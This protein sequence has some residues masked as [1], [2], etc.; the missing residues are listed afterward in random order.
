MGSTSVRHLNLFVPLQTIR[1]CSRLRSSSFKS[2]AIAFAGQKL[3]VLKAC[4]FL[5]W[6]LTRNANR[7]DCLWLIWLSS[8]PLT[9][10]TAKR[11]NICF[12]RIS[13]STSTHEWMWTDFTAVSLR[14]QLK[15][16]FAR[17]DSITSREVSSWFP[18]AKVLSRR[19]VFKNRFPSWSK[20]LRLR[21]SSSTRCSRFT[22]NNSDW[23]S[24][25]R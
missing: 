7:T 23:K 13:W 24:A 20:P 12:F 16:R 2:S 19:L 8:A 4:D 22:G 21:I 14:S 15:S 25:T 11:A 1:L 6:R 10:R 9:F 5:I 17:K 3:L 18:K